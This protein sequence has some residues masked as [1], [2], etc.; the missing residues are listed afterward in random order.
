MKK[1]LLAVLVMLPLAVTGAVKQY[2][3]TWTDVPA[4]QV[5]LGECRVNAGAYAPIGQAPGNGA[6]DFDMD[7]NPGDTVNCRAW[8]TKPGFPDSE[9]SEVAVRIVPLEAP[10]GVQVAPR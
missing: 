4:D 6:I 3:L 8:A 5:V 1:M 2:R 7:V 9:R 10:K